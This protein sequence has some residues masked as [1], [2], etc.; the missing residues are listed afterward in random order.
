MGFLAVVVHFAMR[1]TIADP[2]IEINA[3]GEGAAKRVCNFVRNSRIDVSP[4]RREL[5]PQIALGL[6]VDKAP[7]DGRG[8]WATT[9]KIAHRRGYSVML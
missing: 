8:H 4:A 1:E 2:R 3:F 9:H 6:V 5:D 7:D